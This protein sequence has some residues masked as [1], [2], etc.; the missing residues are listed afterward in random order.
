M[1]IIEK[2]ELLVKLRTP[3]IFAAQ[4]NELKRLPSFAKQSVHPAS[5]SN[6]SVSENL[7]DN[8]KN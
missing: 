3:E 5:D 4:K 8:L 2:T 1:K 7:P 6:A